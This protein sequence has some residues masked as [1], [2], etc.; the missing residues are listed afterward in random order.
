M[1]YTKSDWFVPIWVIS[2]CLR[3]PVKFTPMLN[4][5]PLPMPPI[6]KVFQN[7]QQQVHPILKILKDGVCC[8]HSLLVSVKYQKIWGWYELK[9]LG[10]SNL[11]AG[12]LLEQGV[13]SL[14]P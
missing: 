2:G 9:C 1:F 12:A 13:V 7:R 11:P 5:H 4:L 10:V 14:I 6:L 8:N 3:P